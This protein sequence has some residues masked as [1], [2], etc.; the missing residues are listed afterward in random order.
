[1]LAVKLL[2]LGSAYMEEQQAIE[3]VSAELCL[4]PTPPKKS[5]GLFSNI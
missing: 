3:S 5:E 2:E 4:A 1:M